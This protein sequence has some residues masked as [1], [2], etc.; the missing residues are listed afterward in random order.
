MVDQHASYIFLKY[1]VY[2]YS[3]RIPFDLM[4]HNKTER[5]VFSL[6]TICSNTATI[7]ALSAS[8]KLL[9]VW[10]TM[11][12]LDESILGEFKLLSYVHEKQTESV[13]LKNSINH[14]RTHHQ[15]TFKLHLRLT[16]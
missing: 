11:R 2:Y 12:L 6:R 7:I 1:G 5:I 13:S 10:K 16:E 3:R 8:F 4:S 14:P 15:K 9:K